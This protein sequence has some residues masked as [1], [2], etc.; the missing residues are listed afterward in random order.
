[1]KRETEKGDSSSPMIGS[2]RWE[3]VEKGHKRKQRERPF[4][5]RGPEVVGGAET[6]QSPEEP[7][8]DVRPIAQD[9][10][11]PPSTRARGASWGEY[12]VSPHTHTHTY[13]YG[14]I[15]KSNLEFP[16][17]QRLPRTI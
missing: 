13:P 11:L 6:S 16:H 5:R 12:G 14:Q 17:P 7:E 4:L 10:A 3:A 8:E 15:P 9:A 2:F 1:M